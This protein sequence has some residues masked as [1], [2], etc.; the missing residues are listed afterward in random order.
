MKAFYSLFGVLLLHQVNRGKDDV[1]K[2][3]KDTDAP[4][5]LW[6]MVLY[7]ALNLVYQ[8]CKQSISFSQQSVPVEGHETQQYALQMQIEMTQKCSYFFFCG[9]VSQSEI[10]IVRTI[11]VSTQ[12]HVLIKSTSIGYLFPTNQRDKQISQ[13]S[14]FLVD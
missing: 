10:S 6:Q 13:L 3:K 2:S 5:L 7:V 1:N 8:Y 4:F 14:Q 12:H 9:K 11:Q